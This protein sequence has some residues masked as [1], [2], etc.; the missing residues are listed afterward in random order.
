LSLQVK[1]NSEMIAKRLEQFF[2]DMEYIV[3]DSTYTNDA[4]VDIYT[5]FQE[6]FT[7]FGKPTLQVREAME[8]TP[9]W[10]D[11]LNAMMRETKDDLDVLYGEL[12]V[13]MEGARSIFDLATA[14][15]DGIQVLI[16]GA[17]KLLEDFQIYTE[18]ISEDLYMGDSFED[19]SLINEKNIDLDTSG[20]QIGLPV[21]QKI[22]YAPQALIRVH[23]GSDNSYPGNLLQGVEPKQAD[24]FIP[25]TIRAGDVRPTTDIQDSQFDAVPT[26][27]RSTVRL[28]A[29][30]RGE[31]KYP[32]FM[33][34]GNPDTQFEYEMMVVPNHV[35]VEAEPDKPPYDSGGSDRWGAALLG[36]ALAKIR[37]AAQDPNIG[38]RH[39]MS[40][41]TDPS[42]SFSP[43]LPNHGSN[44]NMQVYAD[45]VFS[46][47]QG[48]DW[49]YNL[50]N[51]NTAYKVRF[52][53]KDWKPD[54]GTVMEVN[55]EFQFTEPVNISELYLNPA[56]LQ[57]VSAEYL[58]AD[59]FT[60]ADIG[61]S[62]LPVVGEDA[63]P[64][65]LWASDLGVE[66]PVEIYGSQTISFPQQRVR[67]ITLYFVSDTPYKCQVAHPYVERQVQLWMRLEKKSGGFS[68][69]RVKHDEYRVW[70]G[71]RYSAG[72]VYIGDI[73]PY[74]G[75]GVATGED[76]AERRG[77]AVPEWVGSAI[78]GAYAGAGNLGGDMADLA[79]AQGYG[80]GV[81]S[82]S[83][84]FE[85]IVDQ[86]VGSFGSD[87]GIGGGIL[88]ESGAFGGTPPIVSNSIEA[89]QDIQRASGVG[90]EFFQKS[91]SQTQAVRIP[92]AR[93]RGGG[94]PTAINEQFVQM[95]VHGDGGWNGYY[96]GMDGRTVAQRADYEYNVKITLK[97]LQSRGYVAQGL[98][99][100]AH[101]QEEDWYL[102]TRD[103]AVAYLQDQATRDFA[104]QDAAAYDVGHKPRSFLR[105]KLGAAI[106]SSVFSLAGKVVT[107]IINSII[108]GLL[109]LFAKCEERLTGV[110]AVEGSEKI[111]Y[112]L[113]GFPAYRFW[114]A[115]KE[116]GIHANRYASSGYII[117]EWYDIG[118][119]ISR[120]SILS[121][122][123]IPSVFYHSYIKY[124]IQ[125]SEGEDWHELE[126]MHGSGTNGLP[127][128]IE[129]NP[130]V[131]INNPAFKEVVRQ[132]AS[133]NIIET[134]KV[135]VKIELSRPESMD[136]YSPRVLS[137]KLGITTKS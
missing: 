27:E 31:N 116:V 61:F 97:D 45:N 76:L 39:P 119:D 109:S 115:L 123:D 32:G 132:D 126:P 65:T 28:A 137:Y 73:L 11:D 21:L 13:L 22:N 124:Y 127:R 121:E 37:E 83:N 99:Y 102:I 6:F 118:A 40:I 44:P 59:H 112:G 77:L 64:I 34:D 53:D 52:V 135:R 50:D 93:V 10:A 70:L 54:G 2:R 129:V 24:L 90:E 91:D 67:A 29:D 16:D 107:S 82:V 47:T 63:V 68:F 89:Y 86:Q 62:T 88:D 79:A 134:Q 12:R 26:I 4:I 42:A 128:Y 25:D 74:R 60:L 56:I 104:Q 49:K 66:V 38:T 108:G 17:E 8:D 20:G 117:S 125:F 75:Q 35:Y 81:G 92:M 101:K 110:D 111:Y 72:N 94:E 30:V 131:S 96:V 80:S 14:E 98:G 113:E 51:N 1:Y 23:G 36:D 58:G 33:A 85:N 69:W 103:V 106:S 95:A 84:A 87:L 41:T 43:V 130:S 5:R 9:P 57:D 7:Q 55:I 114:I 3:K 19:D 48:H 18:E 46:Y 105:E 136:Q 122:E 100:S 133:G 120:V 15:T 71:D 78:V